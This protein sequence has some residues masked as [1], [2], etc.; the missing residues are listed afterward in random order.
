VT[1]CHPNLHLE[2]SINHQEEPSAA[3]AERPRAVKR[4]A[5]A[6]VH[7]RLKAIGLGTNSRTLALLE[8]PHFDDGY[9]AEMVAW[10]QRAGKEP[11]LAIKKIEDG[12]PV[13]GSRPVDLSR[14]IPADLRDIIQH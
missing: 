10:A 9:A 13:P 4:R 2:P 11:G 8:L 3:E 5:A 12:D 6:A 14:Q 7:P 1:E